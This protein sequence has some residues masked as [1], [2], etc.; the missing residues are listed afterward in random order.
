MTLGLKRGYLTATNKEHWRNYMF[1]SISQNDKVDN[2]FISHLN[3]IL[4]LLQQVEDY[5]NCDDKTIFIKYGIT[6]KD[7]TALVTNIKTELN[8]LY[9]RYVNLGYSDLNIACHFKTCYE[10]LYLVA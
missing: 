6:K 1:Y 10:K 4:D 9:E 3:T 2:I 7:V 8:I 5:T